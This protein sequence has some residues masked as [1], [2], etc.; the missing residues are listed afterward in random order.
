MSNEQP[1]DAFGLRQNN[2]YITDPPNI[3]EAFNIHTLLTYIFL[4]FGKKLARA[5]GKVKALTIAPRTTASFTIKIVSLEFIKQQLQNLQTNK[6][7]GLDKIS[8]RLLKDGTDVIAPVLQK[9]IYLSIEQQCVPNSWK[10][11]KVRAL[12]KNGDEKKCDNYR[13]I[14]ILPTASK[15][16]K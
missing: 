12:L 16:L 8:A 1:P 15:I 7:V 9:M 11:A 2:C 13:P 6:A 4:Q 14:S 3:A 5:S 10:S